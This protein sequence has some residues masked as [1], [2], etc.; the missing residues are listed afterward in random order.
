MDPSLFFDEGKRWGR[1]RRIISP[2]L[3]GHH[4][5]ANMIPAIAKVSRQKSADALV[6]RTRMRRYIDCT[7]RGR[8]CLQRH[9]E[10]RVVAPSLYQ[11]LTRPIRNLEMFLA[12]LCAK[13]CTEE[14]LVF[15]YV[16]LPLSYNAPLA[17]KINERVCSKLDDQHGGTVEFV[18]TV[19]EDDNGVRRTHRD[20]PRRQT[21]HL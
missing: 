17:Q 1:S 21:V 10:G 9:P 14:M 11:G 12:D 5:V 2:A 3:N 4:N 7:P 20:H 6:G 15:D 8:R 13:R 18:Q 19:G 16:F